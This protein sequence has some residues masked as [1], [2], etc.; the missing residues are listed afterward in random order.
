MEG[1]SPPLNWIRQVVRVPGDQ[2]AAATPCGGQ[3]ASA[4]STT[5]VATVRLLME[6]ILQDER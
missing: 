1:L 4:A 6:V 2:R 3:T 5:S